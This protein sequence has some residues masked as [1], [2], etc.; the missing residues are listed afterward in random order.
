MSQFNPRRSVAATTTVW[1]RNDAGLWESYLIREQPNSPPHISKL[2]RVPINVP[3]CL[4][5]LSS[6]VA[7]VESERYDEGELV[8]HECGV[9]YGF[10]L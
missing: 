2:K 6:N 1:Q 3:I 9:R 5:C 4:A 10:L 8:C 7:V